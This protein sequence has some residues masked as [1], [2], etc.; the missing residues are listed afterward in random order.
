MTESLTDPLHTRTYPQSMWSRTNISEAIPGVCTPLSWTLWGASSERATRRV[1]NSIGAL[2]RGDLGCP[3]REEDL[4]IGIF[5]GRPALRVDFTCLMGDRIPGTSATAIAEQIFASVPI[6]FESHPDRKY[7]PVVAAKYPLAASRTPGRVRRGRVETA[8]YWEAE[9]PRVAKITD[10]AR[11]SRSFARARDRFEENIFL[12]ASCLF[13]V[14]QPVYDLLAKL[15]AETGRDSANLMA[16]LGGHEETAM[17]AELWDCSRSRLSEDAFVARY[18][19]HGPQAGQM[20]SVV[21]R[22]DPAPLHQILESYRALPDEANPERTAAERTLERQRLENQIF[23]GLRGPRRAWAKGVVGLSKRYLPLRAVAKVAFLQSL[24]AAR[25]TGRQ[26]GKCLADDGHL[27]DPEDIFFL[28]MDEVCAGDFDGL[29]ERV[30]FRRERYE[31]YLRLDLPGTWLGE[32]H[33]T[34]AVVESHDDVTGLDGIGVSP[35]VVEGRVRVVTDPGE[36]EVEPGEIVVGHTTDPSW[37]SV[38]FLSSALVMDIGGQLSHAAVVARELGVPC[39]AD[40]KIA[41][42]A[43]HTGDICRVDGST[44][45]VDILKRAD[46]PD[47]SAPRSRSAELS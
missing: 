34:P 3:S 17:L 8:E 35:G 43:L 13:T 26:I 37:V 36:T 1:F 30:A 41:T 11:L 45:R 42:S 20:H 6:G 28:T 29:G 19:Y 32:S 5:Y 15:I 40:T 25:A 46:Y 27:D 23:A 9:V 12:A 33:A 18:G 39:V 16:G 10:L 21:W 38:M 4:M 14:V 44:G 7:Y 2:G 24:D 31:E 47:R 22:E